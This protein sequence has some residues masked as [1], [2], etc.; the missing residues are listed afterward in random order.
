MSAGFIFFAVSLSALIALLGGYGAI[1]G[2]ATAQTTAHFIG[3]IGAGILLLAIFISSILLITN[4]TLAG[5][6][7]NFDFAGER[8]KIWFHEWR[9]KRRIERTPEI[10][11]AKKRAEKRKGKREHTDD[12]IGPTI[13]ATEVEAMA[14]AAAVGRTEPLFADDDRVSIPT[15]DSPD[16]PY[17]T[18]KVIE[19][20]IETEPVETKP[21]KKKADE[22]P[23]IDE[24][25]EDQLSIPTST[26]DFGR[27]KLPDIG[28][29]ER[30][31]KTVYP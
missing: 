26:Q 15:I 22:K 12:A 23:T 10:S 28:F 3:P 27:Y 19:P 2:E 20:E 30:G 24:E 6:L 25:A 4:F 21:E 8:L 18:E 29:A 14:A 9:A 17:E 31:A 7:S 5:F 11:A 13:A 1:V 16:N